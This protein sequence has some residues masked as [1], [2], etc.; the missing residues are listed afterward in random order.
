MRPSEQDHASDM[1][2]YNSLTEAFRG[3][4]RR[5]MELGERICPRSLPTVEVAG[6]TFRIRR[7]RA[8]L[9]LSRVRRWSVFYALGEFL[10]HL[11]ASNDLRSIAYYSRMWSDFSDDAHS[12]PGSC[13]G[14]RIFRT[15][16]QGPS[17]WRRAQQ[18]LQ[19]DPDTRQAV[20]TLFDAH[21][22]LG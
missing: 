16:H 14:H 15:E 20:I 17:L 13:Y 8:R 9:I 21:T 5:V 11:S 6:A 12:I 7:P 2:A 22:D 4:L 19:S 1:R 10:W 18:Q 3:E